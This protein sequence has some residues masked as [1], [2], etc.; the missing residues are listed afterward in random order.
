MALTT[1]IIALTR[2]PDSGIPRSQQIIFLKYF[3]S[4]S[5]FFYCADRAGDRALP[6]QHPKHPPEC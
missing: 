5:P 1:L 3:I 6:K 2:L 4:N